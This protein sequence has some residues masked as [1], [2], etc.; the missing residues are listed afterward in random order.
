M[1][2]QPTPIEVRYVANAQLALDARK[3]IAA[4]ILDLKKTRR[5]ASDISVSRGTASGISEDFRAQV[6]AMSIEHRKRSI[7]IEESK[8]NDNKTLSEFLANIDMKREAVQ[9]SNTTGRRT[10]IVRIADPRGLATAARSMINSSRI[11]QAAFACVSSERRSGSLPWRRRRA[12][13]RF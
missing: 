13:L 9:Q 8:L 1:T 4:R 5:L 12:I 6:H 10:S 11:R 7:T 2:G 3:V